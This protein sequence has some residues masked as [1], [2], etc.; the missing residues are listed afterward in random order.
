MG[1]HTHF[2][3]VHAVGFF[4]IILVMGTL[5]RLA[6]AHM[7]VSERPLFQNIGKAMAFQY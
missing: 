2:S 6:S 7:T 1:K 5:W 3:A 4:F